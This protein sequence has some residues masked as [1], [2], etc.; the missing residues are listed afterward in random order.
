MLCGRARLSGRGGAVVDEAR[1]GKSKEAALLS[2]AVAAAVARLVATTLLC[3]A[4]SACAVHRRI[5]GRRHRD[6]LLQ[7]LG[8]A[9]GAGIHH[10]SGPLIVPPRGSSCRG[11]VIS[12]AAKA[13]RC[14][15]APGPVADPRCGTIAWL[16]CAGPGR[17]PWLIV[18]SPRCDAVAAAALG[19]LVVGSVSPR[20]QRPALAASNV[21]AH[22]ILG[23]LAP[24]GHTYFC[25]GWSHGRRFLSSVSL[26]CQAV[27]E[28]PCLRAVPH[29]KF[30]GRVPATRWAAAQRPPPAPSPH[31]QAAPAAHGWAECPGPW[32][33][34]LPPGGAM[35]PCNDNHHE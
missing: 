35:E 16:G 13:Q 26:L 32:A 20:L 6:Q 34:S 10:R 1:S 9:P 33:T 19:V 29:R 21:A 23:S 11:P 24:D 17:R 3:L 14:T 25:K 12:L 30:R 27:K 5:R 28:R 22:G 8:A 31:P 2:P 7:Q 15:L 4:A 18:G